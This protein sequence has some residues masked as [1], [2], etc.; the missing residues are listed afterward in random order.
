[1]ENLQPKNE[2][3]EKKLLAFSADDEGNAQA[4]LVLFPDRIVHCS[5]FGWMWYTGT[6]WTT[7]QA[8]AQ[9]NRAIV[10]T[11]KA[12]GQL[13]FAS[14][15]KDSP[16]KALIQAS[17]LSAQRKNSARNQLKDIVS[18]S[19]DQ[20]DK[21]LDRINCKNGVV[22]LRTGEMSE[23]EPTDFFTYC[24]PV[25]YDPHAKSEAWLSF[26]HSVVGGEDAVLSFVQQAV[27]Y[28]LSGRTNEECFFYLQGPT[29][30]GKGT[31]TSVLLALLGGRLASG[32]DFTSFTSTR[33][34]DTQNFDLAGLT[35]CRF[36][37]AAESERFQKINAA[38]IKQ[39]TGND[40][41]RCAHKG[42]PHFTYQ[43][44]FKIWLS[45]N[46]SINMD[47][48][49]DAA[50]GRV[51][52]IRFPNSYYGK[53]DKALKER[54]CNLDSLKGVLA[55]AVEGAKVWY[56]SERGLNAPRAVVQAGREDR[57]ELDYVQQFLDEHYEV[58]TDK[59]IAKELNAW[60]L[61]SDVYLEYKEW[62]ESE[63]VPLKTH[64]LFTQALK[65]KGCTVSKKYITRY[66]QT[67]R[68][69]F[70]LL[71]KKPSH[72]VTSSHQIPSLQQETYF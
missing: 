33:K 44:Q 36:V 58:I 38:K 27:G 35:A 50:W 72:R 18:V 21:G 69:I 47:V 61:P 32:V 53:E 11:L 8:E 57:Q 59:N 54:L 56:E 16:K 45:S 37:A 24:L 26:L 4:T 15:T 51:H 3:R 49:D 14:A 42:R 12:R 48:D 41:I 39:I 5:A 67:R 71:P 6:H 65:A 40:P 10:E 46:F 63:G 22:D 20:F 34:G 62:A 13:A 64:A 55:W 52:V 28:T 2:T 7:E 43:P 9:V 30:S 19:H 23:H 1:M 29:R 68:C 66:S 17:A 60:V 25:D 70:G 31:F